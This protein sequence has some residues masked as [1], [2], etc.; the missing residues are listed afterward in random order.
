MSR[1]INH[2]IIFE[3]WRTFS[4]FYYLF[5]TSAH[6]G[7][8]YLGQGLLPC[9]SLTGEFIDTPSTNVLPF[10]GYKVTI[11]LLFSIA[12]CTD[13]TPVPA[14]EMSAS[15]FDPSVILPGKRKRKK[16]EFISRTRSRGKK[17]W[18]FSVLNSVTAKVHSL[19]R[20]SFVFFERK[21]AR[22]KK[23]VIRRK[24]GSVTKYR[25]R[26]SYGWMETRR[27]RVCIPI[28]ILASL[29][30]HFSM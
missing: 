10:M 12:Q 4:L 16:N 2:L 29:V 7:H 24:S 11:P 27:A 14:T 30:T 3:V 1:V 21:D 13:S 8:S 5:R 28:E 15:R 23:K 22:D 26:V 19:L 25:L 6:H 20:N 18:V 17:C 9:V